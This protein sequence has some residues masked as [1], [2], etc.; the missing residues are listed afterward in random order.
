M[1]FSYFTGLPVGEAPGLPVGEAAGLLF[2]SGFFSPVFSS[3]LS[4]AG[5]AVGDAG[6]VTAGVAVVTGEAG[7]VA[8][9]ALDGFTSVLVHAPRKA[10]MAAKTVNRID[11]LIVFPF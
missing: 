5:L 9:G 11:L 7:A 6:G 4:A 8:G 3:F 1:F 2:A 10:A